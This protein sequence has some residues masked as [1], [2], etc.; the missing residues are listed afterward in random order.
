MRLRVVED[1]TKRWGL[2]MNTRDI[3]ID[4]LGKER[5]MSQFE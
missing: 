1:K 5:L 4:Q 2:R 3:K